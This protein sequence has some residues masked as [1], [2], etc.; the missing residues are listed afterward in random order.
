[1]KEKSKENTSKLSKEIDNK[2]NEVKKETEEYESLKSNHEKEVKD[3]FEN[4]G[5]LKFVK[6]LRFFKKQW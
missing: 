4:I 2:K 1:L 3:L 6:E 5:T